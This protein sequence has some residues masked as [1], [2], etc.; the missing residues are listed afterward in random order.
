MNIHI[1]RTGGTIGAARADGARGSVLA[2]AGPNAAPL[3]VPDGIRVSES[4]PMHILSENMT[5]AHWRDLLLHLDGLALDGKDGLIVTHGTDTLAYTACL[6][7]LAL[8]PPKLPVLLVSANRPPE[9]PASNGR[10][11]LAAA[12]AAIGENIP[13]GVY[14][15]YGNSDGRTYLH[16]GAELLQCP[17]GGDDFFSVFYGGAAG[18][19]LAEI[20]GGKLHLRRAHPAPPLPGGFAAAF[21]GRFR[22]VLAIRPYVGLDYGAYALDGKDAVL[23]GL[24]HSGTAAAFDDEIDGNASILCLARRCAHAGIPLCVAPFP[25]ALARGGR[26]GKTPYETTA[27]MLDAG[28]VPLYGVSFEM[29]LVMLTLGLAPRPGRD[30]ARP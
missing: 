28:I 12:F 3:A 1:V 24:Y 26:G 30:A 7:S 23:H 27:R 21:D 15:V 11:N 19:P 16:A 18:D 8:S 25:Q 9:D 5:L 29:A 6:L 2:P 17:C 4:R 14:A 22:R 13:P 10:G 20:V